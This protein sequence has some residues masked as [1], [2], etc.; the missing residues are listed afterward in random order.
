MSLLILHRNPLEPFPYD[1]W[2]SGY[3][4]DVVILAARDRIEAAGEEVPA[5]ALG[6]ARLE[7]LDDFHDEALVARRAL[8][9]AAEHGVRDL[10]AHHEA[11]VLLAAT[12]RERLGLP[13]SWSADVLPF[14]DK[15]LMKQRAMLGGIEV[16]PHAVPRTRADASEFAARHGFPLVLKDRAGY[17]SIG[18]R[19]MRDAGELE[20]GLA[21]AY[22]AGSPR[23]DLLIE[24][25]VPGRMCHV[26][27]LVVDGRTV[28]VW[29]SQ[30]QYDLA[31]YGTDPGARVDLT[32]DPGDPLTG[33]LTELTDRILAALRSPG[34]RLRDHAFH[35]EIFH[36]PDDR[37][38]LCEIACRTGGG[39]VRELL[40]VAFGLNIGEYAT[41]A[42][43]GLPMPALEPTLRG[44]PRPEPAR[45]A[46]QVLLMK[47]P[48]LVRAVPEVPTEPWVERFWLYARPG[49]VIPPAAGS[50][51]FLTVAIASAPS[52]AECERRLRS[53]GAR[54]EEQTRIETGQTV[55]VL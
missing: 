14:R 28:L 4:G 13:G 30:Y 3:E 45:M 51:D 37:L 12:L 31:S 48:G 36:T 11:D 26:D 17:N 23:D 39:K 46:G 49:E 32:L 29:A 10:I 35:A 16:A 44:G 20:D 5:G 18:L 1:R 27:G 8:E 42:H 25:Y 21:A 19:I 34:G 7:V 41:R 2:L 9:L 22:G 24:A 15:A 43:L 53:L 6:R 40:E 47:R 50:A 55:E 33:R 54:L 52:R 38:V